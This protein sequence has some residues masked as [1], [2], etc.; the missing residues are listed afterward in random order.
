MLSELFIIMQVNA[1]SIRL[2]M[3]R[4]II[5]IS[6]CDVKSYVFFFVLVSVKKG[7]RRSKVSFKLNR[8]EGT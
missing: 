5:L 2:F 8:E 4:L 7:V 3:P 1:V 6:I